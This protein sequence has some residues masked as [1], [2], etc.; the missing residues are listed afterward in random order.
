M[1]K[2]GIHEWDQAMCVSNELDRQSSLMKMTYRLIRKKLD[3]KKFRNLESQSEWKKMYRKFYPVEL[4]MEPVLGTDE[5]LE[6]KSCLAMAISDRIIWIEQRY[7]K[8]YTRPP[9]PHQQHDLPDTLPR[10]HA[11]VRGGGIG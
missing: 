10:L 7:N 5:I 2:A 3:Y 4:S 11:G 1:D 9:S 8:N 6:Y